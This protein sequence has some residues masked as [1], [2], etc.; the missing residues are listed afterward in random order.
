M[1]ALTENLIKEL[2]SQYW[3]QQQRVD[4]VAPIVAAILNLEQTN[5]SVGK[6]YTAEWDEECLT[7]WETGSK[8]PIMKAEWD[9][10]NRCWFENGSSLT[11]ETTNYFQEK[12][13]PF[14]RQAMQ[15]KRE[16]EVSD[17][18]QKSKQQELEL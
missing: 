8:K 15:Q 11:Q 9:D 1:I 18:H 16:R 6:Y 12:V 10:E 2:E 7:L 17:R 13:L 3:E 14:I 4:I 5:L